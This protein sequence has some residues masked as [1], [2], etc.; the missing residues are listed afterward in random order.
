MLIRITF[1]HGLG[2]P[3]MLCALRFDTEAALCAVAEDV[4][5]HAQHFYVTVVNMQLGLTVSRLRHL[6]FPVTSLVSLGNHAGLVAANRD[7]VCL[8]ANKPGCTVDYFPRL[9]KKPADLQSPALVIDCTNCFYKQASQQFVGVDGA[10]A[11][12]VLTRQ[13]GQSD[14]SYLYTSYFYPLSSA[15]DGYSNSASFKTQSAVDAVNL[16]RDGLFL[17]VHTAR[18]HIHLVSTEDGDMVD[19]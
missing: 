10:D 1:A 12:L 2:S 15:G 13:V 19:Y 18:N 14:S 6:D 11:M 16:S 8:W 7:S 3:A 9:L 5:D 4:G 17:V